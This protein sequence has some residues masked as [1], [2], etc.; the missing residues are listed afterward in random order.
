MTIIIIGF[1]ILTLAGILSAGIL[2]GC[3]EGIS[4][5]YEE[6]QSDIDTYSVAGDVIFLPIA[7]EHIKD[8][9]ANGV[10]IIQYVNIKDNTIWVLYEKYKAGYGISFVQQYDKNNNPALYGGDIELLKQKYN[11]NE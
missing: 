4:S 2:S 5:G 3:E 11:V 1:I 6:N 7:Y 8:G 10:D 9:T